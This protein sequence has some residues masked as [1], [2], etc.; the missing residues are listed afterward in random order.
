[1]RLTLITLALV[2][3]LVLIVGCAKTEDAP[4]PAK[5][6]PSTQP[7]AVA[8]PAPTAAPAEPTASA[9]RIGSA[10]QWFPPARLRLTASGGKVIARLYSDDPKG[11]LTGSDIVNS[12][13]MIM[14]LPDIS[15]PAEISGR[16][17]VGH[18][19]SMEKQDPNYGIF[20]NN[21]QDILQPMNVTVRFEGQAPRMNVIVRGTFSMFHLSEQTPNPAP[22][23]VSVVAFLDAKVLEK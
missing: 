7:A 8:N 13:D 2:C 6:A 9:M 19:A 21:Q 22:T 18:S 3:S 5:N 1:M 14:V 16:V 11:V 12:Y 20:L 15:D 10:A 17:W 4:E 23:M